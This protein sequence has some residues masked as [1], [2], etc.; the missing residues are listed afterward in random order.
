M[1]FPISPSPGQLATVDNIQYQYDAAQNRW[2]RV[3]STVTAT[4]HLAITDVTN[5]TNAAT[6]A[7]TVAGGAGVGSDL[8]VAGTVYAESGVNIAS[9][10]Y[11]NSTGASNSLYTAGGAYIGKTLT[12]SGD[13]L[14]QGGVVFNGTSTYVYSTQTFYTASILELHT[15]PGGVYGTWAFDDGK[16]IG[17]RFHYF[18]R[19]S[20]SDANAALV[21]ADDTQYLEWYNTGAESTTSNFVNTTYGTFKTGKIILAGGN[22]NL[23]NTTTGDLQVLGGV[24]IDG[25]LYIKQNS[26]IDGA[27]ILTTASLGSYVV[28]F[29]GGTVSHS[30]QFTDTTQSTSTNTGAVTVTGGVGIGGNLNVGGTARVDEKRVL[31]TASIITQT[32]IASTGNDADGTVT[33]SFIP[34]IQGLTVDWGYVTD[35]VGQITYDFGTF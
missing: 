17:F 20:S 22:A 8:W 25:S 1:S 11:N 3:V 33:L 6:G 24:G 14:F 2:L 16:D 18:N 19:G 32:G 7:L 30:T 13:T 12:V 4:N 34:G 9:G 27:E 35:P 21:L 10:A 28:S 15:P 26:Y 5:A 31:T 29:N 23:G